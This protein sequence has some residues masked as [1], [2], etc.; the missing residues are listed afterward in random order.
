MDVRDFD[1][2]LPPELIAQEPAAAARRGAGFCTS[3]A[4]PAVVTHAD[5]RDLPQLFATA[6]CSSSTTR[7]SFR[8]GCW[9]AA[10]RA[11]A[12]SSVC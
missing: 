4:A 10:S 9:A 1:F 2:D 8:R 5:R 3:I 12:R 6:T 7:A 11:A